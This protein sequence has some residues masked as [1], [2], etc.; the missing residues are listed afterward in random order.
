VASTSAQDSPSLPPAPEPAETTARLLIEYD[1]APFA[2]WAV[3]PGK[4]TVQGELER[5]LETVLRR[6]VALTVAGR[7]DSGVHAWG[8]VASH[9]GAPAPAR[10]LN[11]LLGGEIVVRESV[12]TRPGFDARRDAIGRTYCYRVLARREPSAL[13]RGRALWWPHRTDRGV[14]A[15]CARALT[16]QHD[17]TAFTPAHSQ[18]RHFRRTISHAHWQEHGDVI[19]LWVEADSFLRSMIRVLV[20]TMLDVAGGRRSLE[21]FSSLLEGRPRSQAGVTAPAHG[22]YLASVRYPPEPGGEPAPPLPS[23]QR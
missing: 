8:Q 5:A 18:H 13:E 17:F 16:G 11:A 15:A 2:G 14:L 10:S 23:H 20:A 21:D 19:E 12:A 7:T 6:S 9:P 22:L 4:R 3:Q 1:G